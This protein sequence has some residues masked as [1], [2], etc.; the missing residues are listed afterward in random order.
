MPT[1][2]SAKVEP[3]ASV[4]VAGV[5]VME[6]SVTALTFKGAAP[7]MPSRAA[8]IL[9]VPALRALATPRL[10]GVLLTVATA[11]RLL[12]QVASAVMFCVLAS[13]NVPMAVKGCWVDGAMARSEG[14]TVITVTVTLV[15]LRVTLTL[16][17]FRLAVIVVEPEL[18]ALAWPTV[19]MV[20]TP[21]CEELQV[22][23][24]V[25]ERRDP[26]L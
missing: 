3:S 13:L 1:A 2:F 15:T 18:T 19:V 26:S 20:A 5:S 7:L 23:R 4:A 9:V 22:A 24:L 11:G 6:V 21:V 17:E 14:A 8:E 25:T 10:P 12:D 16:I